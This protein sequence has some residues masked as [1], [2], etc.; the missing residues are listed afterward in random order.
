MG[1]SK[2]RE[3][4]N[5]VKSLSEAL[6]NIVANICGTNNRLGKQNLN[7]SA[8]SNQGV[9]YFDSKNVFS[10]A[11]YIQ[12]IFIYVSNLSIAY[13]EGYASLLKYQRGSTVNKFVKSI[14]SGVKTM[15]QFYGDVKRFNI[16]KNAKNKKL[17][18]WC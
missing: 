14:K 5:I 3:A 12:S 17:H 2:L 6:E 16:V 11:G 8:N 18:C 1:A 10:L 9:P 4:R 13:N 7:D 15:K